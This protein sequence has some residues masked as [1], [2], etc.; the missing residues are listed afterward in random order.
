LL[1]YFLDLAKA[2]LQ[3]CHHAVGVVIGLPLNLGRLPFSAIYY[4]SSALLGRLDQC[5]VVDPSSSLVLGTLH[6]VG[7]RLLRVRHDSFPLSKYLPRIL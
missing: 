2:P 5:V 3:A 7:G 4:R 6:E 1:D